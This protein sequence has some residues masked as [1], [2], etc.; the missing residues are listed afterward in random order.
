MLEHGHGWPRVV[1]LVFR[2]LPRDPR[3]KVCASPFKG[4]GG[5]LLR[6]AGFKPSRK[7]PFI[8]GRCIDQMPPGGATVDIAVLF[9]DVRGS[10]GLAESMGAAAYAAL[11]NRFYGIATG[12][13]LSHDAL[14]DKLIGDEVMALFIKGIS[15]PDYHRK[16]VDAGLELLRAVNSPLDGASLPVGI[17]VH[18]GSA[19]VGN[20]G[21]GGI[22]D[23]TALGDTVNTAARL[24]AVAEPGEL[25]LSRDVLSAAGGEE[26]RGEERT[27]SVRG[28]AEPVAIT[29][30][31][32]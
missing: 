31:R 22:T 21:S 1:R 10:T 2:R 32:A 14:I 26:V 20:V 27:V 4:F 30:V 17:A 15:G 5:S 11:L 13:L 28:R 24:Q 23:F 8:C 19:Y 3:C 7:N 16:A 6:G 18:S 9:A 12:V 29:V 25:V